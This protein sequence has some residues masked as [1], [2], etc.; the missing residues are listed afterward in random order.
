MSRNTINSIPQ[1]DAQ[2]KEE[3]LLLGMLHTEA[4]RIQFGELVVKFKIRGSRITYATIVEAQR[5]VNLDL[6]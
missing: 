4:E 3:R 6:E 5:T 1:R 2:T